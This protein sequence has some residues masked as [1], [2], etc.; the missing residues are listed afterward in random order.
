MKKKA[1]RKE[2][3]VEVKKS[4]NRFIS[5]FFIVAMGVAFFSGIQSCAPDMRATGDAYFDQSRLMDVRVIS[6]MGI[7]E[8]DLEAI[9]AVD[10]VEHAVGSY[11]EDVYCGKTESETVLHVESL[12]GALNVPVVKEGKIPEQAGECFVDASF[13]LA[14]GYQIGDILDITVSSEEDSQ[15]RRR[16]FQISG[17]GFSPNYISFER[18][19]T[20][21]G[22]GSIAAFVYVMPEDFDSEV[23]STAYMSVAGA[24]DTVSYTDEYNDL[25]DTVYDQLED[26]SGLR[27]EIRYDDVMSEAQEKL[28]EARQEVEDGKQ[29]LADAKVELADGKAEA[30]SELAEAESELTDGEQQLEDGKKELA[31]AKKEL[32]D[33]VKELEDGEAEIEEN[34]VT[35]ADARKELEEG[36]QSLNDGEAQYQSGLNEYQRSEKTA[37]KEL[38]KAQRQ[39]D[40]G[41]KQLNDGWKQYNDGMAEITSGEAQLLEA[42]KQL[43]AGQAEYDAAY[44]SAVAQLQAGEQQWKEG[45]AALEQNRKIYESG[46]QELTAKQQE[47]NTGRAQLDAAWSQYKTGA[48]ELA[49]GQTAYETGAAEFAAGQAAYEAGAAELAAGQAAYETGAAELAAGQAA[50]EQAAAAIAP[51]QTAYDAKAAQVQT[52][53]GEYD[54]LVQEKASLESELTSVEQRMSELQSV[55]ESGQTKLNELKAVQSTKEA[56]YQ[57]LHTQL[58]QKS[59]DKAD[60]ETEK[61]AKES[62]YNQLQQEIENKSKNN[63]DVTDLKAQANALQEEIGTVSNKISALQGEIDTLNGNVNTAKSEADAAKAAVSQ[64]ETELAAN[65]TEYNGLDAKRLE[66]PAQISAKTEQVNTKKSGLDTANAELAAKKAELDAVKTPLSEQKAQLDAAAALMAAKKQE[67]DGAAAQL[68]ATKALLDKGASELAANKTALDAA[69]VQM[70]AAKTYLDEQ[71]AKMT[72]GKAALDAGIAQLEGAK[73]QIDAGQAQLDTAKNQIDAGYAELEAAAAELAAGKAEIE[74][75]KADLAAGK[76]ELRKARKTLKASEKE[77]KAGQ[78]EVDKGYKELSNAEKQLKSARRELDLGWAELRSGQSQ[79]ADGERQLE[80]GRQKLADARTE[81]ADAKEQIAD[82][83]KE[84]EENEQKIKDGWEEYE[85]GK[86]EAEQ[87]IAD[88]E[89]KILDAEQELLD[90]EQEIA[91]AQEEIDDLKMPE[92]YVDTRSVLP[93]N[94]SMGENAER[95]ASLAKVFP[96]LF[97][98]VAAL[99][100]LTTMTRMVEEERTQIG[101]MKALGYSKLDIASKYVKYALYATLSGSLFGILVGEKIFPWVVITAYNMMY[102]YM[103]PAIIPY[104]WE[105]GAVAALIALGC[106]L[107]ATM[108]ACGKAL[109]SVPAELM[110]PPAPQKGKK[111]FLEYIPFLW[112]GLNFSWK[113]TVRNLLRYKKR[114]LMTVI[115]IGGCMGLLLVGYGLQDSIMDIGVLQYKDLQR[116]DAMVILDTDAPQEEQDAVIH[117]LQEDPM[118]ESDGIYMMQREDLKSGESGKKWSVYVYVPQDMS[119]LQELFRFRDRE[120]GEEYELTDEGAIITEKIAK[121]YNIKPGDD[122]IL[123]R[124]GEEEISVP[125]AHITENYMSHYLYMTPGLYREIYGKEPEYNCLLYTAAEDRSN[126]EEIGQKLLESDCILNI[127]YTVSLEE[128]IAHMLTAMDAVMIV[129]IISAGLLAFVVLYNL[130]NININERRRELATL[131][132]LGF[133]NGEVGAYVYRENVVLTILGAGLGVFLGKILHGFVITTVEVDACMFGRN[134]NLD[135]FIYGTAFTVLFSVIVN[136]VMY[137]KLKKIDMVE[138]LKSIE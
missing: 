51:L 90:A 18:G 83:E 99:I 60:L 29:E 59:S 45:V 94:S 108:S 48:A 74:K 85:E 44:D 39:I 131:K 120:S 115:G 38:K 138:S 4:M 54:S 24:R 58:N 21:L 3:R 5:I 13:A 20:T 132:V 61:A 86:L 98:L 12:A 68:A 6:T 126:A 57:T 15:L 113:S 33:G 26:M 9:R 136:F 103:P 49:A 114:C 67:L 105:Y 82:A 88:A 71:E 16:A 129:I 102:E 11:M 17:I 125:V 78:D 27:C 119:T 106:T 36:K 124:D 34:A 47:F 55:Y 100:S 137:F 130:N 10:G 77:L 118:V 23:Y 128:Q 95:I 110:R 123:Q 53:Q 116:Y 43:A 25:V 50:Y 91:D 31:D 93:E 76:A 92:W 30:E 79:I 41:R 40:A 1:L 66:L 84:I 37:K 64:K 135:S 80:E 133:Y 117:Q 101:T 89:Q 22:T 121:E 75:N 14:N 56:E 62:A 134:I 32:E 65:R 96:F 122:V 42:E 127:T 70:T 46:V 7:T 35:L 72:E 69:A 63:E 8:E 73:A 109:K 111:V 81:I 107:G 112:S 19:S 28:D 52:L 87:E 2:F 104:H 97:F